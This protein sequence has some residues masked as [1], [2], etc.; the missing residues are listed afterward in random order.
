MNSPSTYAEWCD[1]LDV[2]ESSRID[3]SI[4]DAIR[5]GNALFND[6]ALDRFYCNVC[7]TVQRR[8]NNAQKVFQRQIGNGRGSLLAVSSA[9]KTLAGEYRFVYLIV[10]S[11]PMPEMNKTPL[12]Q[13]IKHQAAQTQDNLRKIAARSQN[14]AL[15]A[16]IY[17]SPISLSEELT[18]QNPPGEVIK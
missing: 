3:L 7:E 18:V 12:L 4:V 1:L 11:L 17:N 15:I 6:T 2:I 5:F 10:E 14:D 13:A 8:I 9:V 16:L